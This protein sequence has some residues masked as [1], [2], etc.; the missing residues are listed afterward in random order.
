MSDRSLSE[1]NI[2]RG[3]GSCT[4]CLWPIY[5][6]GKPWY[7]AIPNRCLLDTE[8]LPKKSHRALASCD[9]KSVSVRYRGPCRSLLLLPLAPRKSRKV[10]ASCNARPVS[11]RHRG[12]CSTF[13]QEKGIYLM[14]RDLL[15]HLIMHLPSKFLLKLRKIT[16]ILAQES[17]DIRPVSA[18]DSLARPV[19][20]S[21]AS[22]IQGSKFS[23][24]HDS[25]PE[26]SKAAR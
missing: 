7:F 10:L 1:N 6:A 13:L 21:F 3:I 16:E 18:N 9:A 20:K 25:S 8:A 12:P 4:V 26:T 11:A 19:D 17:L 15:T 5:R 2:L 23:I 14:L 22:G 24:R